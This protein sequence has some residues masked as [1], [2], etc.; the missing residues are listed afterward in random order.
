MGGLAEINGDD[1]EVRASYATGLISGLRISEDLPVPIGLA[2]G[3]PDFWRSPP[4]WPSAPSAFHG[5][6][7]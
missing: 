1:A 6:K 5:H 2:E 4:P 3:V 7:G